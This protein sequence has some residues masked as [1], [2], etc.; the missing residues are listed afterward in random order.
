MPN[1]N[2]FFQHSAIPEQ[3]VG[4]ELAPCKDVGFI[5]IISPAGI[6][7]NLNAL[8]A[9]ITAFTGLGMAPVENITTPFGVLGGSL[10]QRTVARS[11][12]IA[13]TCVVQAGNYPYVQRILQ[14]IINQV[15]P[16]NSRQTAQDLT[17]RFQLVNS[18]GQPT[19]IVLDTPVIYQSGLEGSTTGLYGETFTLFFVDLNPPDTTELATIQPI[20]NNGNAALGGARTYVVKDSVTGAWSFSTVGQVKSLAYSPSGDL[21]F[22]TLYDSPGFPGRVANRSGTVNQNVTFPASPNTEEVDSII[23]DAAGNPYVGGKFTTPQSY[24]MRLIAGVWTAVGATINGQVRALAFDN[25]VNLYATGD[26]TAPASRAGV[27][28]GTTWAA[29][30]TGLSGQGLCVV[31]GLDGFMYFGGTFVT[32][33]GVT[34]NNIAKWN[35]ALGTFV[36]LGSGMNGTVRSLLVLPNGNIVAAGDFTTAGGITCYRVALWNGTSWQPLSLG[37]NGNIFKILLDPTNGNILAFGGS[38]TGVGDNSYVLSGGYATYNGSVWASMD[39]SISSLVAAVRPD[40]E[41]AVGTD[42]TYNTAGNTVINYTGTAD[43][44]PQIKFTGGLVGLSIVNF[45]T[46]KAIYFKNLIVSNGETALL[47]L[48]GPT[49]ISFISSF[50]GNILGRILGSSDISTF[51]LVPGT[52]VILLFVTGTGLPPGSPKVELIY[53]NV[54]WSVNAGA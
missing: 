42:F 35:P 44:I 54:H 48:N 41:L 22:G 17:L 12:V 33:N 32:A 18:A 1:F 37:L 39:A 25:T 16:S 15:A 36:A 50:S 47:T 29:L 20:L 40:G 10:L 43:S 11:R 23:F 45:T 2:Q 19:G 13:L 31:R 7:T 26:F 34:V 27:W 4:Y 8:L 46:K 6:V 28:N 53:K 49:G 51:G 3:P 52:N 38:I 5:S 24:I 9:R 14:G 30:G 21:F